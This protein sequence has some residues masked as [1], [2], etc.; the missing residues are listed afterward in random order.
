MAAHTYPPYEFLQSYVFDGPDTNAVIPK[1]MYGG[2]SVHTGSGRYYEGREGYGATVESYVILAMD[3]R[4]FHIGR[5]V[6][7]TALLPS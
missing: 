2:R 6:A 4:R 7:R 5:P 1:G 3:E